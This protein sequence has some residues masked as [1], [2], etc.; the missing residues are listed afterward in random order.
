[1]SAPRRGPPPLPTTPHLPTKLHLPTGFSAELL[2]LGLWGPAEV[3]LIYVL[4]ELVGR[5][6]RPAALHVG[7]EPWGLYDLV[8][9]RVAEGSTPRTLDYLYLLPES[10]RAA[11]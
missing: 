2:L 4:G 6:E 3:H 5:V 7:Q 11:A 8:G 9:R 1:M 10:R